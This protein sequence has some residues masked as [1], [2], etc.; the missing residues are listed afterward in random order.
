MPRKAGI[1]HKSAMSRIATLPPI[2][3]DSASKRAAASV[4]VVQPVTVRSARILALL[5]VLGA[6]REMPA[7]RDPQKV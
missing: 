4:D 3:D 2:A 6:L 1:G 7:V 5:L